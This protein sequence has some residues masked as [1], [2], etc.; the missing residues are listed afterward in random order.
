MSDRQ[1]QIINAALAVFSKYGVSKSTMNDIAQEAGISRQTL[2]NAYPGKEELLRASVRRTIETTFQEV[3]AAWAEETDLSLKLEKFF[4]IMP[5]R[6][7][8]MAHSSPEMKELLDG[9]HKVAAEE[10]EEAQK[11]WE[12]RFET[13][14]GAQK[15][16][17][18]L[19][20]PKS[21]A[22]F[23]FTTSINAKYNADVRE[24]V[25]SR[26]SHL[27]ASV[28]ARLAQT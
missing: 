12:H 23:F 14:F 20:D 15:G 13:L 18:N 28:L 1:T 11:G 25:E 10:M 21:F 4:E 26:L 5:L 17:E 22:D 7:Y 27:K 9:I 3:D 24:V 6:Y 8:D 19:G 2:Y 16:A